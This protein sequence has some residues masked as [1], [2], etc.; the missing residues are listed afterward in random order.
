MSIH[1]ELST[2]DASLDLSQY[3][4]IRGLLT[5][6]LGENTEHI[7]PSVTPP[8]ISAEV[9][10]IQLFFNIFNKQFNQTFSQTLETYG[11]YS[12]YD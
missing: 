1:G 10:Y 4:L 11:R 2:L 9:S 7:L 8:P 5:Y 12:R 6:N 3:Q